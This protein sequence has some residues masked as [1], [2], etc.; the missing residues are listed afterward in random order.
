M[1][2]AAI[3]DSQLCEFGHSDVLIEQYLCSVPNLVQISVTVTE[4][5][6]LYNASEIHLMTS[7]EL[8]STFGHVVTPHG[9]PVM[10]LP[11][12]FGA[13]IIQS[14]VI[15]IFLKLKMAAAAIL[16]LVGGAIGP[17]M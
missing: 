11:I 1:A 5:D 6:A 3:F 12:K 14:E 7:H 16:D 4:I 13:D 9:R 8:T 15:D 17:P 10:H 2:T